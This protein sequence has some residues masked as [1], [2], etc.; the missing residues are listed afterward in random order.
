MSNP[1]WIY[2]GICRCSVSTQ[3]HSALLEVEQQTWAGSSWLRGTSTTFHITKQVLAPECWFVLCS[4]AGHAHL[5]LKLRVLPHLSPGRGGWCCPRAAGDTS[6]AVLPPPKKALK[7]NVKLAKING[8]CEQSP[9]MCRALVLPWQATWNPN[10]GLGFH[11][12]LPCKGPRGDAASSART[13]LFGF[14]SRNLGSSSLC[15]KVVF[16]R[17]L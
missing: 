3:T 1:R 10:K 4:S 5:Y 12:D 16:L 2:G 8:Q 6:Q 9:K 17:F 15:F 11:G 14:G 7:I 13:A